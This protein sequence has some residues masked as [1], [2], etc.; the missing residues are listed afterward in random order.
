MGVQDA[1]HN[2]ALDD[3][4]PHHRRVVWVGVLSPHRLG[5]GLPGMAAWGGEE[6]KCIR[7]MEILAAKK[8]TW[9][10]MEGCVYVCIKVFYLV[11]GKQEH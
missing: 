3:V 4:R 2:G 7:V 8:I 9:K 10:E 11:L 1:P 6:N 5:N